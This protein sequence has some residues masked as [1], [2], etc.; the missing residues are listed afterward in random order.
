MKIDEFEFQDKNG[1]EIE[2]TF[3]DNSVSKV[4]AMD[5]SLEETVE[6]AEEKPKKV[7]QGETTE[8]TH[9][10]K[11][12]VIVNELNGS[13]AAAAVEL[14]KVLIWLNNDPKN[15]RVWNTIDNKTGLKM[16]KAVAIFKKDFFGG[17]VY[18][19]EYI[20]INK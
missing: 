9:I 17:V 5:G 6:T 20:F 12:D 2:P 19:Y 14:A 13:D 8:S 4:I 15:T 16:I 3:I 10:K 7:E 1:N 11:D 18:K